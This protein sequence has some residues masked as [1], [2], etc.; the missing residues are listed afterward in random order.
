MKKS[1]KLFLCT[2][3]GLV[4]TGLNAQWSTNSA[5]NTAVCSAAGY[6][7]RPEI[8][9]D[10]AGGAIITWEDASN[11]YAQRL[12]SLGIPQWTLDGVAICTATNIQRLPTIA[13]DGNGGAII[14]WQDFRSG[15][16]NTYIYV[17]SINSS[18]AVQWASNGVAI[19]TAINNR[20]TPIIVSDGLGGAIIT[21]TDER[22]MGLTLNDIYAQ[23]INSAGV[24][25]WTLDGI[26]ICTE[27]SYQR[28]PKIISDGLGG[29]FITWEDNRLNGF[30]SFDI[31]AQHIDQ[32]GALVVGW[33]INGNQI[34]SAANNQI[35]P[36]ITYDGSGG[37]I[38]AWSDGRIG[39]EI[40]A[41]R[42]NS[43]GNT[44]WTANG[45]LVT[46]SVGEIQ[47]IIIVS[48]ASSGAIVTW[49][50]FRNGLDYDIYAHRL[51]STGLVSGTWTANGNL[52]C[53]AINDQAISGIVPD[54]SGGAIITW[55]DFRNG[56]SNKVYAQKINT[57]GTT[58][59]TG[60]GAGICTAADTRYFASI[61]SDGSG[62]AIIAWDDVRNGIS[63]VDINAQNICSG[64][65]LGL[66]VPSIPAA[67]TGF[68][69]VCVGSSNTYSV[70]LV[71]GVTYNW[72]LPGGWSGTSTTNLIIAT[73]GATNGNIS[74]SASNSCGTSTLS[75]L[76]ITVNSAL[77]SSWSNSSTTNTPVSIATRV[78]ENPKS[79]S[80]GAGGSIITWQD[81][82]SGG[83]NYNIYAQRINNLGVVQWTTDGVALC[84]A[85]G[86]Q[87]NPSIVSDGAGGA[88][89]TWQ[90]NRGANSDIYAQRINS[91]GTVQW[92][93]N[94]VVI[95]NEINN[96]QIPTIV[97]DG[98]NGAI[99]AWQDNRG[100][101]NFDI[102]AQRILAAGTVSWTANGVVICNS[103]GNQEFPTIASN[104][105]GNIITWQDKRGGATSDIYAQ[106]IITTTGIV[107]WA[108]NGVV[109]CNSID[110]QQFPNIVGTG[111]SGQ[112]V[113]VWQDKRGG[114]NFDV[115]TQRISTGGMVSWTANGVAICNSTGDQT[116][117]SLIADGSSGAIISWQDKRGGAT[118]DIYAQKIL[119]AGTVSWTA[120]GVVICN[121]ADDQQAPSIT[122]DA[123]IGGII[124][125]Q[126]KRST[127]NFDI[128]IQRVNTS[129]VVQWTA[130]GVALST[131]TGDQKIPTIISNQTGGAIV[132]WQDNRGGANTD[133]YAQNIC[134]NG[135]IG[136]VAPAA[137][138][139]ISGPAP[140]CSASVNQYSI[141]EVCS[142][143]S[144]TWTLPVGWS[145]SS[146][147]ASISAIANGGSGN[148]IV[149][150]NNS[151]GS[152]IA[153]IKAVVVLICGEAN[154]TDL[155]DIVVSNGVNLY[156]NPNNGSFTLE[157]IELAEKIIVID[158]LGKVVLDFVPNSTISNISLENQHNGLYFVK[159]VTGDN[160]IVKRMMRNK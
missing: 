28:F 151:C 40:Y 62:G 31:Y 15:T 70:P 121:S 103:T 59:W 12:N 41:Q 45:N 141:A 71:A 147:T 104:G 127:T 107:S 29:A 43:S 36:D 56:T 92:T 149:T 133:I 19:C 18:G 153:A 131:A 135:V 155:E 159:I 123:S 157:T 117:P 1:I 54:G 8:I 74:V 90:D 85:T 88:I 39:N 21:W 58:I 113:I 46:T 60:N 3:S 49:K 47:N 76:G 22:N 115:Y 63:N 124:T 20:E 100:G 23:K 114:S 118:S 14:T 35:D 86:N 78:Q 106:K 95:C 134:A 126:D 148:I 140:I 81:S 26:P 91:S 80:D 139:A 64:G 33:V 125:W 55:L 84:T 96:Q 53:N 116:V 132:A 128:Y 142:A 111:S 34:C 152:S 17:Q 138:G 87:I 120:N 112:C 7:G 93:S 5:V 11:I 73:A 72:T 97:T 144:Y 25:Q 67:I 48:D 145:G 32:L 77:V 99:I 110:D 146:T 10:G 51:L 61:V 66:L 42:I 2:I 150:A 154:P 83:T 6:Q 137:P 52:I 50:D 65:S 98:S 109:I 30:F 57:S 82:R 89:V 143:T 108:A 136:S 9:S 158:A 119:S 38:I 4:V 13:S 24:T 94:G 37:A 160:Q 130:N 44:Q 68:T 75:T 129:G 69:S 102:Y 156:P 16:S 122:P 101:V 105:T 27:I 79:V